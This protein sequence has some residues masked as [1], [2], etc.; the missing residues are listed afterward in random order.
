MRFIADLHVHSKYSMATAKDLDLERLHEAAQLR[1]ISLVGTGDFTHPAWYAELKEKLVPAGEGVFR[2]R[3]DLAA[4]ADD[5]VPESCRGDVRFMLQCEISNIYKKDGATRKNHHVI[6]VPDLDAAARFNARLDAVGNIT[7]DGR[8]ILGMDA[9]DLLEIL[10]ECSPDAILI[11]AHIWTPWFSVLGS[12]SGFDAVADCY[13]D[14]IGEIFAAETG[15][16]SDPPMNWR[17]S[18]LDRF[19]LVSNSDAHSPATLGRNANVFDTDPAYPAI[20]DALK[21]KDPARCLGTL[22]LYPQEGK[23]HYDGHRKCGVCLHPDQTRDLDGRC[24]ECGKPVTVGVL[25]RV[26][27]LAD[28]PEGTV[29]ET[30][31]PC[32]HI[33]PL[34]EIL[35]EILGV[36]PKSKKVQTQYGRIL[37]LFGPELPILLDRPTEEIDRAGV[38]HLGEAIARMRAEQ[39][40]LQP[41][42]D[43]EYGVIRLFT[44][45]EREAWSGQRSLFAAD[46]GPPSTP[47]SAGVPKRQTA[48]SREKKAAPEPEAPP[49]PEPAPAMV[50]DASPPFPAR[51]WKHPEILA[52]LNDHQRAAAVHEGGPLLVVA[53]PGAGKT[54]TLTHR[55]AHLIAERGVP[56]ERILAV[57]FTNKA[58]GEMAGRLADL[59]DGTASPPLTATFHAFCLRFLKG[60][61]PDRVLIDAEGQRDLAGEAA[62]RVKAAGGK[63]PW[64]A[65]AALARIGLAKQR[66]LGPDDDLGPVLPE[67]GATGADR[68]RAVYSAYQALL[69]REHGLDFEDLILRTVRLLEADPGLLSAQRDRFP[70][71]LVDEYQDINPGQHRLVKLLAGDGAGLC[72]IGDPDQSIYGFRGSDVGL[73]H[74]FATD[75]PGARVIRLTRNYRS[76]EAILEASHH[77]IRRQSGPG[78][79]R[80]YSG[81]EGIASVSVRELATERAEAVAVGKRIEAMV[82]GTG[83]QAID[84]GKVAGDEGSDHSFSDFAVL[85][86]T[87]AQGEILF[88]VLTDAGIP[89]QMASR[90]RLFSGEGI[91]ETLAWLRIS[92]GTATFADLERVAAWESENIG[93]RDLERLRARLSET[94]LPLSAALPRLAA[95]GAMG[96]EDPKLPAV[97]QRIE[98]LRIDLAG[99]SAG[100]RLAALAARSPLSE[101]IEQDPRLRDAMDRLGELAAPYG[102]DVAGFLSAA[103]LLSDP[104]V[105]DPR[106]QK[107]S[108]MTIHAAKGLEFPVVFITGCE[109]DLIPFRRSPDAPADLDEERRLFYV[110][111]TRAREQLFFT[112]ARK[113]RI[114]GR[115]LDREISPFVADIEERLLTRE[116]S[117]GKK[118]KKAHVQL[119]LFD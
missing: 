78:G 32:R 49:S 110:A 21:A 97:L 28:R 19:A 65:D 2:L 90:D 58:A 62:R 115:T 15:L 23:Y 27:E 93:R 36:G 24:P 108:L 117:A 85:Y 88:E 39:V 14:L 86:R 18:A 9:R 59:L 34:P 56:P 57:T 3:D 29:P 80:V 30:A 113:R 73:F 72:A 116:R 68:L 4:A 111:M 79:E 20:R 112:W 16:S 61:L 104:D 10:L 96:T 70:Y 106:A 66:L 101:R 67:E 102:D 92:A 45:E 118:V 11:P 52:A 63:L 8:P 33:I 103:A 89:C 48:K 17:V 77:V 41:G 47:K 40:H 55:I 35:S 5:G 69:D 13:G 76:V 114:H 46:A 6:F 54:R 91:P 31:L 95:S 37:E 99:R 42:Y 74:G 64:R 38:R 50:R 26:A 1:G 7:S 25:S 75:Y 82:G 105:R 87:S 119:D 84:F 83:F 51:Q 60:H 53:G 81:I 100:D 109:K 71:L 22:D 98:E 94:G 107:V 44:G 43:G 12:K